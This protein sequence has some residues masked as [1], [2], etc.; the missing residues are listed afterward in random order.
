MSDKPCVVI[1][2]QDGA[3]PDVRDELPL[4]RAGA[5]PVLHPGLVLRQANLVLRNRFTLPAWIHTGS[6]IAFHAAARAGEVFEVR[7]IPGPS[8]ITAALSVAVR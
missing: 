2:H 7:A 1:A 6:R 3:G 5:A 8:A 4:Y